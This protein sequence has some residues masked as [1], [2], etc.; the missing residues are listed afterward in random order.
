MICGSFWTSLPCSI[1]VEI[2]NTQKQPSTLTFLNFWFAIQKVGRGQSG[3][4]RSKHYR[5][6][7]A[8][9]SQKLFKHD[10]SLNRFY[11]PKPMLLN[12]FASRSQPKYGTKL[13]LFGTHRSTKNYAT[14]PGVM[15]VC[16]SCVKTAEKISV[17]N[18]AKIFQSSSTFS[19]LKLIFT[20]E[21]GQLMKPGFECLV[22]EYPQ[23]QKHFNRVTCGRSDITLLQESAVLSPA[24]CF[25]QA[26]SKNVHH[27]P[28]I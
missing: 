11:P 12:T 8:G 6:V 14:S 17:S 3:P 23:K 18:F 22:H 20:F 10:D 1:Y 19:I 25:R 16:F 21:D 24:D 2:Q 13:K 5:S 15:N 27:P 9:L 7:D 26:Y 28:A 4:K